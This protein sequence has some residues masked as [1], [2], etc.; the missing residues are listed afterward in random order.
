MSQQK[1]NR[2]SDDTYKRRLF[3]D[4]RL[5]S[6][7]VST[8]AAYFL[9]GIHSL[10]SV[11]QAQI[12]AAAFYPSSGDCTLACHYYF[13]GIHYFVSVWRNVPFPDRI[14][15]PELK[16]FPLAVLNPDHRTAQRHYAICAEHYD[17]YPTGIFPPCCVLR[18]AELFQDSRNLF[19]CHIRHRNHTI[20]YR[21][22][23]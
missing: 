4:L 14:S 13:P 22:F 16:T 19:S 5:S 6:A 7:S 15:C 23:Q 21:P 8:Y 18:K 9:C 11:P 2:T 20:L 12:R 17:V 10:Q 1:P 3:Y